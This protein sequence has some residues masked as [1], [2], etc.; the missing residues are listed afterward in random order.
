MNN[1]SS[2]NVTYVSDFC[3]P[4]KR[5]LNDVGTQEVA[6]ADADGGG[7]VN[8]AGVFFSDSRSARLRDPRGNGVLGPKVRI[9]EERSRD[10]V[11]CVG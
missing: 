2:T 7:D 1:M 10:L 8:R 9:I 4:S 11:G 6:E 3:K 5:L